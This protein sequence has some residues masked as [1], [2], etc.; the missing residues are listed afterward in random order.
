MLVSDAACEVVTGE[1]ADHPSANLRAKF[2]EMGSG[3]SEGAPAPLGGQSTQVGRW[4]I[5]D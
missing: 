3:L 1:L 5:V 4:R 2:P